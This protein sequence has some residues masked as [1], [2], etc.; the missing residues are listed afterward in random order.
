MSVM[1]NLESG[2]VV[3]LRDGSVV[4]VEFIAYMPNDLHMDY[5][6]VVKLEGYEAAAYTEQGH[7]SHYLDSPIDILEIKEEL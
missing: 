7:W 4:N 6:Y 3:C 5:D 2:M 1:S